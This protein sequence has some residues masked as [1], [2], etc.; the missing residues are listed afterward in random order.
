MG[1]DDIE[2]RIMPA[3][4]GKSQLDGRFGWPNFVLQGAVN[5]GHSYFDTL[6]I[7]NAIEHS[8]GLT[9][10]KVQT[11]LLD[12]SNQVTGDIEN[13]RFESVLLNLLDPN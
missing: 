9:A 8:T 4:K 13:I 12:C 11:F 7:L 3:D 10:T 2:L 6:T 5:E 1:V